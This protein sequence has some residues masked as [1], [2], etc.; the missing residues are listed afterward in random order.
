MEGYDKREGV[1]DITLRSSITN[2]RK[3][4]KKA[5]ES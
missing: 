2:L 3:W 1:R 5:G 4:L